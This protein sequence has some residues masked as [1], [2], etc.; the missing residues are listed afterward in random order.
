MLP[1]YKAGLGYAIHIDGG[2]GDELR[3]YE[4]KLWS[5]RHEWRNHL[6]G[7]SLQLMRIYLTHYFLG[8]FGPNQIYGLFYRRLF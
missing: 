5:Q 3:R 4:R 7:P 1:K 6:D 8:D 2:T